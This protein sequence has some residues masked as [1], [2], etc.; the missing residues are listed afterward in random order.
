M[1]PELDPQQ[2]ALI[3]EGA[4]VLALAGALTFSSSTEYNAGDLALISSATA[5]GAWHGGWA[6]VL[7]RDGEFPQKEIAGGAV[8]GGSAGFLG[9]MLLS[10]LIDPDPGDVT[11]SFLLASAFAGTGAGLALAVPDSDRRAAVLT[12][13][14]AG[15]LGIGVSALAAPY[16][17]Y[18]ESDIT[19][20]AMLQLA[21][22]GHGWFLPRAWSEDPT[23]KMSRGGVLL[24]A[25][26][27]ALIGRA[28]DD[29]D[30]VCR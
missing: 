14:A 7:R 18:K 25:G 27:G 23:E 26:A 9:G 4:G 17:Q 20:L 28:L 1:F 6:P 5:L 10:Q 12:L 3:L 30:I 22:A 15:L 13:E 2:S 16:T 8:L 21:G 19:L 24:G 29:G 11:E